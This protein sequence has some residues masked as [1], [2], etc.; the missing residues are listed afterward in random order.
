MNASK[1]RRVRNKGKE[2]EMTV[3]KEMTA[4][5]AQIAALQE[6]LGEMAKGKEEFRRI[7]CRLLD[8]IKLEK[9]SKIPFM[10]SF[11]VSWL[12]HHLIFC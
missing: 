1:N 2:R 4:M 11:K 7:N 5:N 10:Q 12:A 6:Q 8:E 3:R 9:E